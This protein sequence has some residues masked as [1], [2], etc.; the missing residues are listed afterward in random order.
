[1]EIPPDFFGEQIAPIIR[2]NSRSPRDVCAGFRRS[3]DGGS[4]T[5]E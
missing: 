1:M 2:I 3:T 5:I 4:L